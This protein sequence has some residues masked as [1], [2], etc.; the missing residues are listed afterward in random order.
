MSSDDSPDTRDSGATP[1]AGQLANIIESNSFAD[2][3]RQQQFEEN[4]RNGQPYFNGPQSETPAK[5]VSPSE[6]LKCQRKI[7]YKHRNA[8]EE[9]ED[10][11]GIFLF[12]S[13]FEEEVA[14]K[15][16]D[17]V[18]DADGMYL[19]NSMW[20]NFEVRTDDGPVQ[21]RGSTDP[22]IVDEESQP[23]LLTEIKTTGSLNLTEPKRHHLAQAHA[24]M[25]GLSRKY[26]REVRDVVLLYAERDT[27]KVKTFHEEFDAEFWKQI[28]EWM[29]EN[30]WHQMVGL[31]PPA[32]PEYSWECEYCDYQERCGEGQNLVSD[33]DAEGLVPGH[34]DYPKQKVRDYLK[35][36]PDQALTPSLAHEYP[37]LA[38]E[39]EVSDWVCEDC[40]TTVRWDREKPKW[41]ILPDCPE[42]G[43]QT[44][45]KLTDPDP[46]AQASRTGNDS[47][48]QRDD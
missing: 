48:G 20:V 14:E 6:L 18:V 26:G 7:Y 13:H 3:Y 5:K 8:P 44:A 38:E 27:L 39:F 29:H 1:S 43:G 19:R 21:V 12:G 35:G 24:Y 47:G 4:I 34:T 36:N 42:C 46:K 30:K 41:G 17:D 45:A 10:P 16:L 33:L 23:I 2:W 40:R 22:V 9:T 25:E 31:L 11:D 15:F 32:D 37:S 28:V